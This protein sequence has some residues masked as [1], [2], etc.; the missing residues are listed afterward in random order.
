[1][2]DNSWATPI[3]QN[4]L[5]LGVDLVVHSAS[6]YIGG[7]SDVVAGVAAGS[8]ALIDRLRGELYPYVGG[9]LAPFD[10]WLLI[11]GLRTL[12][13]RMLAHQASALEIARRLARCAR[14]DPVNHPGLGALPPR[15]CAAP[16]GLFSFEVGEGSTS[17]PSATRSASSSSA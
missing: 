12:P 9:R 11:R 7:H 5:A 15:A 2:I 1:M 17:A 4:P 8:R 3:F 16:P 6:K 14:G 13:V 10:A